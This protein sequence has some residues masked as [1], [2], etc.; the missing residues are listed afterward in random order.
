MIEFSSYSN[1]RIV[2]STK[3]YKRYCYKFKTQV[4]FLAFPFTQKVQKIAFDS[5]NWMFSNFE[6]CKTV[7]KVSVNDAGEICLVLSLD[8]VVWLDAVVHIAYNAY[9]SISTYQLLSCRSLFLLSYNLWPRCDF[10]KVSL[11]ISLIV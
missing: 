6:L 4:I 8:S 1:M 11:V 7:A 3:K 5:S 10:I 2:F 9:T